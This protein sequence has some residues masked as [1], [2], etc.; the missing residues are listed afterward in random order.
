MRRSLLT[1]ATAL[2]LSW[3][4][5]ATSVWAV[6]PVAPPPPIVRGLD[7]PPA[8]VLP[9]G[10]DADAFL[11]HVQDREAEP[12]EL[13]GTSALSAV[14]T[15]WSDDY[16]GS[17][18]HHHQGCDHDH[19]SHDNNHYDDDDDPPDSCHRALRP[20]LEDRKSVV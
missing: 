6:A 16:S 17:H 20:I 12:A 4:M 15:A 2:V 9:A 18:H 5:P 8:V 13:G 1:R 19:D 3:L 14:E 7:L 11:G 10:W